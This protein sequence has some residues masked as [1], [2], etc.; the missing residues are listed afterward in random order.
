VECERYRIADLVVDVGTYA[1]TRNGQEVP[2][3]GLSFDL[4]I[5]LA[6]RAPAVVSG[7][8]LA[9]AVWEQAAVSDETVIQRV[10][11]L[12]RA[13]GDDAREPRYVR[14]VRGRGYCI[15]PEVRSGDE[16][17]EAPGKRSGS[18][19]SRLWKGTPLAGRLV[20][21]LSLLA[22]A[23]LLLALP[24]LRA[25]APRQGAV[26]GVRTHAT[27]ADELVARA[28]EYLSRHREADNELAI[29]LYR[30]ALREAPGHPGAL[31]GLSF[32]LSQ[33]VTKFNYPGAERKAA[34]ELA[35]RALRIDPGL[36]VAHHARALSL[37][38][39]GRFSEALA[40][41]KRAVELDPDRQWAASSAAYVLFVKGRLAE[42]LEA[43]I[44]LA[45]GDE[46]TPYVETQMG[47]ALAALGFDAA[48]TVWLD[49]ALQLH[50]D[51]VFAALA[52]ARVRLT[53]GR[54]REAGQLARE[55]LERGIERSELHGILG[56]VALLEGD[57]GAAEAFYR[58]ALEV[59]PR[60]DDARVRLAILEMEDSVSD[61]LSAE[62]CR[63]MSRELLEWRRSGDESPDTA[64]LE[65]LL[66][67]A[68]GDEAAALAAL[69]A[70][71]E[72]GYRDADWLLLDPMLE[73][74]R[75]GDGLQTRID[76]IRLLVEA[77]RRKVLNAAWLPP[78]F[79]SP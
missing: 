57:R 79:L 39:Q 52:F 43:N 68:L 59:S 74:L 18:R 29:D 23:G 55:A 28:D 40:E 19:A 15:V 54:L 35:D 6:R 21:L 67:T 17:R 4:L 14:S 77:E 10:A 32:G 25:R 62:A 71:V 66:A 36:A 45:V 65:S 69:D 51:S 1:V 20:A 47:T 22:L 11:L 64:Y 38:S 24:R 48:A 72:L 16:P 75:S 60:L 42:A 12:R 76:R 46:P 30:Q 3:P 37:D 73:R 8:E 53:R 63:E 58:R 33:G 31:A 78:G 2:L 13:L 7:D 49:R 26:R 50:P 5:A 34:L 70:A 41:Y 61:A 27:S 44:H 56:H 9:A